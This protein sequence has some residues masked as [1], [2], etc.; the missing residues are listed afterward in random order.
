MRRSG[1]MF[2]SQRHKKRQAGSS[3]ENFVTLRPEKNFSSILTS[4]LRQVGNVWGV[5]KELGFGLSLG[6]HLWSFKTRFVK[7]RRVGFSL[8]EL[9]GYLNDI[10]GLTHLFIKYGI[11]SFP[12]FSLE[13]R[14][15]AKKKKREREREREREK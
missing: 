2:A 14:A 7:T 13:K 1:R 8:K 10:K 6:P 3:Q 12:S 11:F 15:P 4:L 9:G 5:V